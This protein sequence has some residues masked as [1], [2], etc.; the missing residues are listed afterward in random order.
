[1][2]LGLGRGNILIID[3]L[4]ENVQV[5]A[6]LLTS[7]GYNITFA[8][9]AVDAYKRLSHVRIDLILLD[10]WMPEVDGLELC[11]QLKQHSQYQ[12]IPII[13]V[14]A[15][16]D[17][18][19]IAAAFEQGAADYL[20][21]PYR[22]AELLARVKA[23]LKLRHQAL[24]IEH[25]KAQLET[26]VAHVKDGLLVLNHQGEIIFANPAAAGLFGYSVDALIGRELGLP[27]AGD[28]TELELVTPQGILHT[29]L[30]LSEVN[31]LNQPAT[32]VSIRD[33]EERYQAEQT[34][35][36]LLA[37]QNNRVQALHRLAITD[38]LTGLANR[39][40][41][42]LQISECLE[43]FHNTGESLL[44]ALLDIDYFKQVNDRYGHPVGDYTLRTIAETM[45][46]V[47]TTATFQNVIISRWAGDEFGLIFPNFQIQDAWQAC[48]LVRQAVAQLS[49]N[50][51]AVSVDDLTQSPWISSTKS[52]TLMSPVEVGVDDEQ[53]YN[54]GDRLEI[55]V[56]L[57]LGLVS[58]AAL[59]QEVIEQS[60][61]L[62]LQPTDDSVLPDPMACE[63]VQH[64]IHAADQALYQAKKAGRNCTHIFDPRES[65]YT[66][67]NCAIDAAT[68][69]SM[70]P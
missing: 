38:A 6:S 55:H 32:I 30:R 46:Q 68:L 42:Y 66:T 10:L 44:I 12:E 57:S 69:L 53:H 11:H 59:P 20:T 33:I 24:E 28:R 13:F 9:N 54:S 70:H 7:E 56:T 50:P 36:Q 18:V 14:T 26:I 22:K 16:H 27:L 52:P 51:D 63:V 29:E 21:K 5:L 48:E 43:R 8:L 64:L 23:H 47:F 17:E 37:E 35:H 62:L 60:K 15:C 58:L 40:A 1:M 61:T 2:P 39:R 25:R 3:D 4:P 41:F 34:V 19:H 65:E 49:I 31:W 45:E 67:Q